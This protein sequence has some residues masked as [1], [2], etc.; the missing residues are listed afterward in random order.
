MQKCTAGSRCWICNSSKTALK[1]QGIDP[2]KL[3]TENFAITDMNYGTS[4]SVYQCT[5]CGFLFC[6]EAVNVS[7]F[8]QELRDEEYENTRRHRSLQAQ[9]ILRQIKNYKHSGSLLDIGSGSGILVEEAIK[10]G[11]EAMGIEPS[12][13]LVKQAQKLS[14][15][16]KEGFFPDAIGKSKYDV[17]TLIDVLEHVNSPLMLL[18]NI[19]KHLKSGGVTIIATPDVRSI[20][21]RVLGKRWWNYRVAHIGYFDK[22]TI[23][24]ALEKAGL[25]P[26]AW[27]R[28][29]WFF[30]LDYLLLRL[31]KYIPKLDYLAKIE[32]I[33]NIT[34]PLNSFDSWAVV[35]KKT[36]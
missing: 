21:A 20:A 27:Y 30:A 33:K 19:S 25:E 29:T 14:I 22:K 8:Y 9:K 15:S 35:A 32:F 11:Y 7:S 23:K 4:L 5:N 2:L 13:W 16:V 17:I 28:P 34:V 18:K 3:K 1:F 36:K 6:P 10:S 24:L 12:S 26:I 31:G